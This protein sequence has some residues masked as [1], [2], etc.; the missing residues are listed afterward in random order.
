MMDYGEQVVQVLLFFGTVFLKF[1]DNFVKC[2]V[3]FLETFTH[4]A[5]SEGG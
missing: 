1:S 4:P 2:V 3:E 5:I